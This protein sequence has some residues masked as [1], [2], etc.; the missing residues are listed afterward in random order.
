MGLDRFHG[1]GPDGQFLPGDMLP[2]SSTPEPLGGHHDAFGLP[3]SMAHHFNPVLS[4]SLA[5][6]HGPHPGGHHPHQ[7]MQ[8]M[9]GEVW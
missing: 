9:A 5:H 4:P 3:R 1:L 6:H 2:P 7:Q 8:E